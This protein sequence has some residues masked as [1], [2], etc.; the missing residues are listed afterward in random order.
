MNIEHIE[1]Q[2]GTAKSDHKW[3]FGQF[4]LFYREK[5]EDCYVGKYSLDLVDIWE[6]SIWEIQCE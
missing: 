6:I 3:T 5:T 4:L 1:V 2:I